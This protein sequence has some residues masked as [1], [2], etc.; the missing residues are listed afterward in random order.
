MKGRTW[1]WNDRPPS[2][3]K[4]IIS[5]TYENSANELAHLTTEASVWRM[6]V[7]YCYSVCNN[8]VCVYFLHCFPAI[9]QSRWLFSQKQESFSW[10]KRKP[11]FVPSRW[12]LDPPQKVLSKLQWMLEWSL[13]LLTFWWDVDNNSSQFMRQNRCKIGRPGHIYLLM[14]SFTT[15]HILLPAFTFLLEMGSPQSR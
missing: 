11:I 4:K 3:S 2:A 14:V 1:V 7:S 10:N 5:F 8:A 12:P 9:N 13:C 6:V 15:Q